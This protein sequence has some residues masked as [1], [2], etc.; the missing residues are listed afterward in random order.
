M[1]LYFCAFILFVIGF[2][3]HAQWSDYNYERSINEVTADWHSIP[4]PDEMF[5]KVK[6]SLKDVRIY[7]ISKDN[8]T[9]EAPY[10]LKINSEQFKSKQH[11]FEIINQTKTKNGFYYTFKLDE[12]TSISNIN[13]K[14]KEDNYDW[15]VTLEGSQ[16]Q[17][18]WFTILEDY[19][20]LSIKNSSTDYQFTDLVFPPASYRYFRVL[21]K[22]ENQPELLASKIFKQQKTDGVFVDH[23][24]KNFSITE[25]KKRKSTIIDV[26]LEHSVPVSRLMVNV[27][28][29]YDYF[30][31]ASLTYLADSVE[32]EKGWKYDYK[33]IKT[34]TLNSLEA[35]EF[36]F[37]DVIARKFRVVVHN[38]DNQPLDI[39]SVSLK[40]FSYELVARFSEPASYQLVYGNKKAHKP[41]YDIL[42]V[43]KNIPQNLKAL[44]LGPVQKVKKKEVA[45]ISALFENEF[46]L[47]AIMGIIILVLGGFTFKM[48]KNTDS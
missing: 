25:D 3:A 35:N 33:T 46:W 17:K 48:L 22:S 39:T 16:H 27:K 5:D 8:D 23:H 14:F 15:K 38:A 2:N 31:S 19:R 20:I 43:K 36:E 7:G 12:E 44:T 42:K 11:S 41:N 45:G 32:T 47:W 4:I 26:E 18:Q 21:V 34:G 10:F 13:L 37:N 6:A 40:G 1:K 24:L 30:R 29:D 28:N 9:I